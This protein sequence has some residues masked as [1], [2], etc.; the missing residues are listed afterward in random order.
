MEG[1]LGL[2]VETVDVV[3]PA[4]PSF[5]DDRE[6]PPVAGGV[7][8]AMRNAPL[9]DRVADDADAVCVGDHHWTLEKAGLLHPSCAGHFPI[10]VER[11]P[12]G[13]DRIAHGIFTARENRGDAGADGA[14]ADLE[15]AFTEVER[16]VAH[17]NAWNV[18]DGV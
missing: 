3:E 1:V 11:P 14:F 5:G 15:F 13:K 10:A 12:T 6:R 8:L 16:G 18:G 7:G 4:I 2:D 9:D 17:G